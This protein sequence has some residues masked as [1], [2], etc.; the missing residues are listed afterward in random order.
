M[1]KWIVDMMHIWRWRSHSAAPSVGQTLFLLWAHPLLSS[2]HRALLV[3]A[4]RLH[5]MRSGS[6]LWHL[7][8]YHCLLCKL[9]CSKAPQDPVSVWATGSNCKAMYC[10]D[11]NANIWALLFHFYTGITP[12][13]SSLLI[14][15]VHLRWKMQSYF[16]WYISAD[17]IIT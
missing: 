13:K 5:M 9:W 14:F 11:K 4:L 6:Y 7:C 3:V 15:N 17:V 1:N 10:L 12:W 2:W 16:Q 8:D